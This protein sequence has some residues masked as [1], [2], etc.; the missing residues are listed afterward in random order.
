MHSAT[1][2]RIRKFFRNRKLTVEKRQRRKNHTEI[3][4][5]LLFFS[6]FVSSL[7]SNVSE[8]FVFVAFS[9]R[10]AFFDQMKNHLI[11]FSWK[12][13]NPAESEKCTHLFQFVYCFSPN[14]TKTNKKKPPRF[15]VYARIKMWQSDFGESFPNPGLTS[16]WKTKATQFKPLRRW[17]TYLDTA[18]RRQ[19]NCVSTRSV[20]SMDVLKFMSNMKLKFYTKTFNHKL[21]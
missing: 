17:W 10:L 21:L 18:G 6:P 16:T 19:H 2:I 5:Y 1:A 9:P 14:E 8:P 3:I 20:C 15:S 13:D 4:V 7:S 11:V 12:A